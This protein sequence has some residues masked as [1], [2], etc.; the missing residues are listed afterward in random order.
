MTSALLDERDRRWLNIRHELKENGLDMLL[1][2]SDG[3]IERRDSMRYVSDMGAPLMW[4]YVLF[5]LDGD[6]IGINMR[7]DCW[8]DDRRTLPLRGGWVPES[9]PYAPFIADIIRELNIE[10]GNIGMEGDFI[11]VPVY[12]KLVKELPEATFTPTN[13][14]RKLKRIKSPAELKLVERGTEI[15]DKAFEA[16]LNIARP[17]ITW[18]DIT[19]EICKTLFH[20]G[21]EDIGGYPMS[22]SAG[23]IKPGD[24]YNFYPETQAAGGY[25][26]QLGRLISFGEP[27]K[28]LR[29]AWE[30]NVKAQQKGEEKLRAGQTGADVMRAINDTLKGSSYTGAPRSS[31]HAIGLGVLERPFISLDDETVF[32]PGMVVS[33]HPVFSPPVDAFEAN[34]DMFIVT[35]DKPRKLSKITSEIK[36]I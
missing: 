25:W 3:H 34:A 15:M 21:A 4:R 16:A 7:G 23:I 29:A 6:P 5:P 14:I 22:R 36:V 27:K 13:I 8:I 1:V 31:G 20:W 24:S 26:I 11:P 17:G 28:E 30:L 10:R 32:E 2:I 19:S 9:E 18:N 35:E 33:I 12:Q